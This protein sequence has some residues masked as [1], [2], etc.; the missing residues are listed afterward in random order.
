MSGVLRGAAVITKTA[1]E[2]S[3]LAVFQPMFSGS[4]L[5]S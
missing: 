3:P 2:L 1:E 5:A 4:E